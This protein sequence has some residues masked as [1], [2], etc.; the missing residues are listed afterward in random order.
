MTDD[1]IGDEG[2]DE[3]GE[4]AVMGIARVEERATS[5]ASRV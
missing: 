1:G 5:Q 4:F 3:E 2:T